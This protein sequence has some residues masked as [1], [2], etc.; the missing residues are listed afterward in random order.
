MLIHEVYIDGYKNIR[1][2]KL[3][4]SKAMVVLLSRNNF[5]KTN[6]LNGIKDGF[7]FLSK[8]SLT[9]A[10]Y[11][12]SG[13]YKDM[14]SE[15]H[16]TFTFQVKLKLN[17]DDDI[18]YRYRYSIGKI[19]DAGNV[20][21]CEEE[22]AC[23]DGNEISERPLLKRNLE[24]PEDVYLYTRGNNKLG[25]FGAYESRS[26]LYIR[27]FSETL[28]DKKDG[29][30][31][32][33]SSATLKEI[34]EVFKCLTARSVGE[35]LVDENTN[36]K[37]FSKVAEKLEN[38][39]ESSRAKFEKFTKYF[40][41]LFTQYKSLKIQKLANK[42][43]LI[44]IRKAHEK[45]ETI[46]TLSFG[47]RRVLR[48][49][50]E[51]LISESPLIFIEELENGIHPKMFVDVANIIY[52]IVT[53]SQSKSR[54]IVTSHSMSL[55]SLLAFSL[56]IVHFGPTV[57]MLNDSDYDKARF[58]N[59]SRITKAGQEDIKKEMERIRSTTGVGEFIYDYDDIPEMA[60][61]ILKWLE[62]GEQIYTG[63]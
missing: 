2:T 5:G 31:W 48:L 46:E 47:T 57:H 8:N 26:L 18:I 55:V 6:V 28:L 20:G 61:K 30:T 56:D 21:V 16:S 36:L 49:L 45:E 29:D 23:I 43:H 25:P 22:L 54:L 39:D 60:E 13:V 1:N 34:R 50:Y 58:A 17:C 3:H 4:F 42:P 10:E 38:L 24:N 59:F 12:D 51:T 40:L 37:D 35:F 52:E 11:I 53:D 41:K 27:A 33:E 44:F 9:S 14:F 63:R 62:N 7:N 19:D 15:K 32:D